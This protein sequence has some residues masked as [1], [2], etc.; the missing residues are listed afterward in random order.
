[1]SVLNRSEIITAANAKTRYRL[2]GHEAEVGSRMSA[3]GTAV[4][5]CLLSGM[6]GDDLKSVIRSSLPVRPDTDIRE[7]KKKILIEARKNGY[8]IDD[9][10]FDPDLRCVAA[11]VYDYQ[12]EITAAISAC[13]DSSSLSL[14]RCQEI[15]GDVVKCADEISRK[16]GGIR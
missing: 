5:Q 9:G 8:V 15:C 6:S 10:G 13:G 16:I 3:L 2:S 11:P 1:M 4:G 12:G 7:L 14:Q